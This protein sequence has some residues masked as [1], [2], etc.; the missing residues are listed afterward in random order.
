VLSLGGRG[1][2]HNK[3]SDPPRQ[4]TAWSLIPGGGGVNSGKSAL[5]GTLQWESKLWRRGEGMADVRSPWGGGV[6]W[7]GEKNRRRDKC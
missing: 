5:L 6:G 1:G 3:N 7:D 4:A 2:G